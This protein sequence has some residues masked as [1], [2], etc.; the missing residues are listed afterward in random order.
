[1]MLMIILVDFY[2]SDVYITLGY[3]LSAVSMLLLVVGLI[4]M[5][6]LGR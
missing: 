4:K 5:I 3:V 2:S 6:Y 1:M